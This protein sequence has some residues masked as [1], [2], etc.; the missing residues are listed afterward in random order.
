MEVLDDCSPPDTPIFLPTEM[1]VEV[2]KYLDHRDLCNL[3][4]VSS[5]LSRAATDSTLWSDIDPGL[6]RRKIV[7]NGL[8]KF[9]LVQ[10]FSGI[11]RLHLYNY[12]T[13][14]SS[15]EVN[16][17]DLSEE[18]SV[19][20]RHIVDHEGF[21][22]LQKLQLYNINLANVPAKY[23]SEALVKITEVNLFDM[24]IIKEQWK[25]LFKTMATEG[26]NKLEKLSILHFL[27]CKK[28]IEMI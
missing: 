13:Q 17:D 28:S 5:H 25:K 6:L 3:A 15:L 12:G 18:Y 26:D 24:K 16:P 23:L 22:K 14:R 4:L 7:V 11:K 8:K 27:R 21:R 20:F 10:R 9:V 1:W 19:L 2:G